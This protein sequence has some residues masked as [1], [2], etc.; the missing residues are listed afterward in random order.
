MSEHRDDDGP[1]GSEPSN[2][3][4]AFMRTAAAVA[5]G[6]GVL[7]AGGDAK[8]DKPKQKNR[9]QFSSNIAPAALTTENIA[10]ITD[11]IT[12]ALAQEAQAGIEQAPLGFHIRIGGGH[13][14]VFSKTADHKNVSHSQVIIDGSGSG[15]F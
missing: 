15:P 11:A 13:S 1:E 6:A 10:K 14:R 3:R 8:A 9:F 2:P 7:V 12:A 5:V 4:R